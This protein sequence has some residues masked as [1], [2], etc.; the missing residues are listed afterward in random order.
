MDK[1]LRSCLKKK[2]LTHLSLNHDV[3]NSF[4]FSKTY[5][6]LQ[7]SKRRTGPKTIF[8]TISIFF[9]KYREGG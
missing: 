5:L 3:G 8:N 7:G 9:S 6:K 1:A 4:L 2:G